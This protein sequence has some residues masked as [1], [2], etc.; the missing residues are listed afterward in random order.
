MKLMVFDAGP[1]IS[2][3][4][5]NL[6]WLLSPLK[7]RFKGDFCITEAVKKELVDRPVQTKKFKFEAIQVEQ[8]IE[9]K[10]LKVLKQ[11]DFFVNGARL[12]SLANNI[13]RT[14]V[15]SVPIVQRGEMESLA[16]TILLDADAF[17]TDER[18]TR[19]IIEAPE[20]LRQILEKRL[21][22]KITINDDALHELE[23]QTR[24]INIIRSVELVTMA[25]EQGLLDKFIVA[26]PNARKELL[27]SVLWG[28]KLNGCAVGENEINQILNLESKRLL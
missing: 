7:Q 22:A 16:A 6:L 11:N 18:I 24:H 9:S 20:A 2:L 8:Q 15:G 28:V 1:V 23:E 13:F 17:A 4:T 19:M 25:Y 21:H 12:Q 3:T 10:V 14:N 5:N 27:E 26:L